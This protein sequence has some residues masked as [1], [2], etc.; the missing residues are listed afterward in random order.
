MN[1]IEIG[2]A[3]TGGAGRVT[4]WLDLAHYPDGSSMRA[5]VVIVTGA[6]AGPTV[7]L[8]ACVHGN[9]YCGTQI[10]HTLLRSL[11]PDGMAGRVV[12]LPALNITAFNAGIR[13]SPFEKYNGGDMNRNFP[14]DP[15]G[16]LTQ[17]MAAAVYPHL[18]NHA[19]YLVDFHTAHTHDVHWALYAALDGKVGETGE[20]MAKAFGYRDTLATP[21]G[22]L[23]GSAMMT[24]A[25][26]GIPALIVEAG[27]KGP[28]FLRKNVEDAAERLRNVLRAL[29]ILDGEVDDHGPIANFS[30]FDW[31]HAPRGGLFRPSV[32]CGDAISAGQVIGEYFDIYGAPSG[33]AKSPRDGTVLA[34]HPGPVMTNGETLVHIGHDPRK[35]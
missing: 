17:Q 5:P 4:G 8:H 2:T 29:E 32:A 7:W 33:T 1:D 24:A 21:P 10:I 23:T 15:G 35:D 18:K 34:I 26:D 27:G 3:R 28:A 16:S 9:E 20:R 30:G 19:D 22:M 12:A 31:V 25:G 11:D 13:M 6:K 14:G